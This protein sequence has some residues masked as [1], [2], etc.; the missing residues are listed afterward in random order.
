MTIFSLIKFFVGIIV[1]VFLTI[2]FPVI[3]KE[4]TQVSYECYGVLSIG[5]SILLSIALALY[6]V[7][8]VD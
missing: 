7:Y 6:M 8:V 5:L 3:I 4:K 2:A 1:T